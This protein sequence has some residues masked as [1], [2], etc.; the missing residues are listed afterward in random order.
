LLFEFACSLVP[1]S[2]YYQRIHLSF[3]FLLRIDEHYSFS[4]LIRIR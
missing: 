2:L 3:S 1:V 4:I